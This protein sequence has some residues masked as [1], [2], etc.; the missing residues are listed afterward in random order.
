[1]NVITGLIKAN[2]P[3]RISFAVSSQIDSR[4]IIDT[5]GAEKLLGRGDMLYLPVGRIRPQRVHGCYI[6]EAEIRRVTEHWLA[7]GQPRYQIGEDDLTEDAF[8]DKGAAGKD[9]QSDEKFFEAGQLVISA[10]I[11]ST[12][13]LQ[14]KLK[15]GYARAAR[16]MDLLEEEG[17]VSASEG[18]KPRE[19]RMTMERFREM[20]NTGE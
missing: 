3:T 2:I 11:A 7:Q 1:V 13:F 9:D 8:T 15:I 17:V 16:L 12:S 19:I 4:T 10:G 18:N 20:G 6:S 14:R 5:P